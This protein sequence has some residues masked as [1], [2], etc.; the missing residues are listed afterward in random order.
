MSDL[1]ITDE[2]AGARETFALRVGAA[3]LSLQRY[4]EGSDDPSEVARCL[5]LLR[6]LKDDIAMVYPDVERHLL[7]CMSDRQVT[8]EG[9]GVVETHK[10]TKRTKW[11]HVALVRDVVSHLMAVHG[12]DMAPQETASCL[13]DY[14]GFGPGKVVAL[15]EAGLQPDEYCEEQENG[16]SVTLPP[17][18]F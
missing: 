2:G 18:T 4:A 13:R 6:D 15:R 5:A 10:R 11:D 3:L 9:L 7:A 12:K 17:R 8:V 16:W 1:P 14:I